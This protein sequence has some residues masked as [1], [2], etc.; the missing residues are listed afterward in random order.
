MPKPSVDNILGSIEYVVAAYCPGAGG[1]VDGEYVVD[2]V[3]AHFVSNVAHGPQQLA[4][5]LACY[6]MSL[7]ENVDQ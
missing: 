6:V 4:N 1:F 3:P 7:L 5:E 2:L